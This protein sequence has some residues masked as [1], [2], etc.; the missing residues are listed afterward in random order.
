[1]KMS[2]TVT[3]SGSDSMEQKFQKT[4]MKNPNLHKDVSM[5]LHSVIR[6]MYGFDDEESR[7]VSFSAGREANSQPETKT[8]LN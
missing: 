1:M 4:A 2:F 3:L 7:V 6:G 5:M 8:L